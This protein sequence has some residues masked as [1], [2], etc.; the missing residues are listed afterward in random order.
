MF[1]LVAVI[2]ALPIAGLLAFAATRPNTFRVQRRARIAAEPEAIF[3]LIADLRRWEAW[4]PYEKMDPGMERTFSG[5]ESGKGAAYEW[6]GNRNAGAG[7][8]EIM[9]AVPHSKVVIQLDFMRPFKSSNVA[10][11]T[12]EPDGDAT[13]VTWALDGPSPYISKL[14]GV[15]INMDRMIGQQFEEGLE[16]LKA[17][18]EA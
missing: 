6:S 15:F 7:R 8:M 17:T 3:A 14:V 5:A 9:D 2:V 13:V 10:E 11:F 1:N 4:S 16:A 12:L 18:A